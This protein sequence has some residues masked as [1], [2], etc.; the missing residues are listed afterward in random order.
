M[1]SQ[2][3]RCLK[4]MNILNSKNLKKK[5]PSMIYTDF[6]IILVPEDNGKQNNEVLQ[7]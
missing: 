5:I 1:V 2:G 6:E 4:K 3:L 7:T